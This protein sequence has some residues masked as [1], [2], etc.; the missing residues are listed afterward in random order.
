MGQTDRMMTEAEALQDPGARGSRC[1]RGRESRAPLADIRRWPWVISLL[2]LAGIPVVRAADG[3]PAV[4]GRVPRGHQGAGPAV[5]PRRDGTLRGG[6]RQ[7]GDRADHRRLRR[8]SRAEG[9]AAYSRA[10]ATSHAV[11][12]DTDLL[13]WSS[14]MGQQERAAY[15]AC[16]AAIELAVAAA[17][18]AG[19]RERLEGQAR[20]ARRALAHPGPPRAGH[21]HLA[22]PDQRR[23]DRGVGAGSPGR[24][25]PSRPQ[26][27]AAAARAAGPARRAAAHA[28]LAARPRHRRAAADRP[29]LHRA[30]PG[31]RGGELFGW[32]PTGGL[33]EQRG[34]APPG[35]RRLPAAHPARPG[36]ARD[37]RGAAQRLGPGADQDRAADG[38]RRR[39]PLAHRDR[40][41]HRT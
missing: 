6:L 10:L 39:G 37:G 11:P 8:S 7:R 40:V 28:D 21:G 26:R 13:A 1:R 38:R 29:A 18:P 4:G 12:P 17:R 20:R 30:R 19:R 34:Q 24:A 9:I 15:D 3:L 25:V 31:R 36:A 5:H 41:A 23:A 22:Q 27:D 32:G 33:A 14:V 35:A 2:R 16:A